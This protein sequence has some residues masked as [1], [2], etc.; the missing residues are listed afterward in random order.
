MAEIR[1][2]SNWFNFLSTLLLV[3]ALSRGCLARVYTEKH[4]IGWFDETVRLPCEFPYTDVL[5]LY[6]TDSNGETKVS[7]FKGEPVSFDERF[8]L[9]DDYSVDILNLTVSDE[10]E[11]TCRLELDSGDGYVNSS[12]LTIYA[13]PSVPQVTP[14]VPQSTNNPYQHLCIVEAANTYPFNLECV[15]SG[16]RP[17]VTLEW[18]SSGK[19][20]QPLGNPSRRTLPDGR[21]ERE[22]TISVAAKEDEEQN[23]T[24]TVRGNATN[25]ADRSTTVTVLVPPPSTAIAEPVRS[26]L[27]VGGKVAIS[28]FVILLLIAI[29]IVALFVTLLVLRRKKKLPP[30]GEGVLNVIPFLRSVYLPIPDPE[31]V[32]LQRI[33]EELADRRERLSDF[34][35][36]RDGSIVKSAHIGLFGEMSAGKSSFI[37]SLEFAFTGKYKESQVVGDKESGGGKTIA[38]T[39]LK[40]TDSIHIFD[41]RGMADFQKSYLT[42]VTAQLR[43]ER[44]PDIEE[45]KPSEQEEIH[46]GVF[47]YKMSQ[48]N[49]QYGLGFIGDFAKELRQHTGHPPMIVITHAAS[50]AESKREDIKRELATQDVNENVYFFEN[51]TKNHCLEDEEKSIELLKFLEDA[52]RNSELS[53]AH[54]DRRKKVTRVEPKA[55]A[56]KEKKTRQKHE[57]EQ[58]STSNDT[59]KEDKA[60][61]KKGILGW[62]SSWF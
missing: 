31:E 50:L 28:I 23:Y 32:R 55:K 22:V 6:W 60:S 39:V 14:C 48:F 49:R 59:Q 35:F 16:F 19:V 33:T 13:S 38:R 11:Y 25:G 34:K 54:T 46:C 2:A 43:G 51:Y 17:D 27:S 20:K 26:G 53:V 41:N 45:I 30:L 7:Y 9:N 15:V 8:R 61:E 3:C 62:L 12:E 10:G 37:N 4:V 21:S 24:C 56:K 44:G 40:L 58:P 29:G 18:T 42:E 1:K 52:I 57:E 5:A 47:V 36:E